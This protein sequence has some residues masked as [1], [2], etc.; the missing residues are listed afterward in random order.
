[1]IHVSNNASR[2]RIQAASLS[3]LI[4]SLALV[5]ATSGKP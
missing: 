2:L 4:A 3:V 5:S 1:M